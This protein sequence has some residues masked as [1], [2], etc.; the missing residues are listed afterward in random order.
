MSIN[1]SEAVQYLFFYIDIVTYKLKGDKLQPQ[2][3]YT[4]LP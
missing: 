4:G 1:I 3:L 2:C